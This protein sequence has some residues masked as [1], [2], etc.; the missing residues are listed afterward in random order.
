MA[1]SDEQP[2]EMGA[3]LSKRSPST[4][5]PFPTWARLSLLALIL[6]FVVVHFVAIFRENVNWDELALLARSAQAQRS[7]VLVGGGRPGLA[8]LILI[9]FVE[10][11]TNSITAVVNAR[12]LWS[13][14]TFGY[15]GGIYALASH[16]DG[17]R[18]WSTAGFVALGLIA[19]VPL[20]QRW[21]LQVRTDQPALAFATW[22]GVVLLVSRRRAPLAA[23]AGALF[24]VGFLFTQKAL[25][26]SA[27]SGLLALGAAWLERDLRLRRDLAR[28]VYTAAGVGGI[29]ALYRI[30]LGA[31]YDI[32]NI[33]IAGSIQSARNY[34]HFGWAVYEA[35]LP[36]LVPHAIVI[37]LL[38]VLTLRGFRGGH[39]LFRPVVLGWSILVLG[40]IIVFVHSSRFPYFWMTLGAFFAMTAAVVVSMLPQS[41]T[42]RTRRLLLAF[43]G[44]LL[45][46]RAVPGADEILE[47]T[48]S[49]Q[50]RSMA[51][52][53]RNFPDTAIGFHPERG[54]FCRERPG[55]FTTYFL[56]IIKS[57]FTGDKGHDNMEAFAKSFRELPV[58]FMID[59]FR[60]ALF[61]E[62]IR[63]FWA[64]T[65]V[66]YTDGV[67][68][69]GR[70]VHGI[71]GTVIPFEALVAG[72]YT[73]HLPEGHPAET[74]TVG[75]QLLKPGGIIQL[76]AGR[77]DIVLQG[78]IDIGLVA[79]R[80]AEPPQPETIQAFYNP[81][82]L[83]EGDGRRNWSLFAMITGLWQ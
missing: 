17:R 64:N 25:Y 68:V 38:I 23:L 53:N 24:A 9:P 77:N 48:I 22:G 36:L 73:F 63:Q 31:L 79:L 37:L 47:D 51:F 80:L 32:P 26:L 35:A 70:Y 30:I 57:E 29:Y 66:R 61:P 12:L 20:F 56:P 75:G 13:V 44:L 49:Q 15:L 69:P 1:P 42:T 62:P 71:A 52:A 74:I 39:A 11:C 59:S 82:V 27:L 16:I 3:S 40:T 72:E 54:L 21:S 4:N 58:A 33:T 45:F 10:G 19:L 55:D 2:I 50:S 46:A 28:L 41:L 14:F 5:L 8:T 76:P 78:A 43:L 6:A 18:R 83:I 67:M 81:A 34:A 65:Y 60:L 7:G